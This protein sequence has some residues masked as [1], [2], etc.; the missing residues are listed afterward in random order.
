MQQKARRHTVLTTVLFITILAYSQSLTHLDATFRQVRESSMLTEAQVLTGRFTFD[1]PDHV[2][3]QYDSGAQA[4][5]PAPIL[6]F[7]SGAVSGS[8]L[9]E[10]EDFQVIQNESLLVLTPKRNRL[11]KLF[12]RIEI[13]LDKDGIAEQVVMHEPTGDTTSI[14]FYVLSRK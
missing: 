10:N 2:V 6:K 9:Q 7:I 4:T 14:T 3:W 11:R 8:L 12:D 13:R 5:L 1:A